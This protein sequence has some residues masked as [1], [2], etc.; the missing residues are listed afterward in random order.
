MTGI[1]PARILV[2]GVGGAPGFDLA[3][4]LTE[5]GHD[6]IGTDTNPLAAGLLIPG[7]TARTAVPA[8]N[9]GYGT[10]LT[11]ACRDL[12]PAAIFSAVEHELPELIRLQDELRSLGVRTWLPTASAVEACLDKAVFHQVLTRSGLPVPRTFLPDQMSGIPAGMPLIVKPRRGQGARDVHPCATPQQ[13]AV[14]CDLTA[15]PL[16]QERISGQE[17]TADCLVDRD[18]RAAVVLRYRLMVKGGL[19]MVSATFRDEQTEELV[20]QVLAATGITG[21][22]C[23]QGIITTAPGTL[24]VRFLEA[25]ARFAGSFR[26]SEAAGADLAGQAVNGMFGRPVDHHALTYQPGVTVTRYVAPLTTHVIS[27]EE[28]CDH[29]RYAA[30]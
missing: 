1:P 23:V 27:E 25:N 24:R 6:V 7:I 3:A 30:R 21:P 22:C 16:I 8:E 2:T 14:L 19:S 9:P 4:R 29:R 10:W 12:R 11:R 20:R 5:L 13:A 18:G 17:F 26:V 15:D 28:A